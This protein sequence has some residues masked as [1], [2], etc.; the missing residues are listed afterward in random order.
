[1][2][3]LLLAMTGSTSTAMH[4]KECQSLSAAHVAEE[5]EVSTALARIWTDSAEGSP[6]EHEEGFYAY[7]CRALKPDTCPEEYDYTTEIDYWET[8]SQ[9]TATASLVRSDES[10]R[11]VLSSH[12]HPGV[13]VGTPGSNDDFENEIA[14][15]SDQQ[16]INELGV[17]GSYSWGLGSNPANTTL[18]FI[19]PEVMAE[20]AW[21]C[22]DVPPV[23]PACDTGTLP[24]DRPTGDGAHS[25]G[26]PHLVTF[27][28]YA[29]SLQSV[30][31]FILAQSQDGSVV[32]QAR[33]QAAFGSER[34]A[35]N[36][37]VAMN[38]AG[39]T[40]ELG[41]GG[42]EAAELMVNSEPVE[43][44][45]VSSLG[46]DQGGR[47][48]RDSNSY[49]FVWPDG[50]Q[51][52]ISDSGT[53]IGINVHVAVGHRENMSGLLGDFNQELE[54]EL[55]LQGESTRFE[56]YDLATLHGAFADSW[57]VTDEN[58]LFS[59]ASGQSTATF[60]DKTFP[61]ELFD[62]DSFPEADRLEAAQT[63][64]NSGVTDPFLTEACV[65]DLLTTGE[66]QFVQAAADVQQ[67]LESPL[68]SA[69]IPLSPDSGEAC[70]CESLFTSTPMDSPPWKTSYLKMRTAPDAG[71]TLDNTESFLQHESMGLLAFSE[72]GS[73][74]CQYDVGVSPF[75]QQELEMTETQ[76][77]ACLGVIENSAREWFLSG[78]TLEIS[79]NYETEVAVTS[80]DEISC[81]H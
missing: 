38:I 40:V 50:T 21:Q 35:M 34:V 56:P 36:V 7:H 73:E 76:Y 71:C 54:N 13:G 45:S 15:D 74:Y 70:P 65:M 52:Q 59:Y 29:Y 14:S 23:T 4:A 46:L 12:T 9:D 10:C 27:D 61:V 32:V 53:F 62:I 69:D 18:V 81:S 39:D 31:E 49:R 17:T 60:T 24:S 77:S 68:I 8:G 75:E 67:T 41:A 79:R 44:D 55:V 19:V 28:S 22:G 57:R 58:S 6:G 37:A 16:A 2:S 42:A 72:T 48:E 80:V 63:C 43:L 78:N 51:V 26:D 64:L 30:G 33:Q 3:W 20:P 25:F 47:I 11:L 66:S 5:P 1:M